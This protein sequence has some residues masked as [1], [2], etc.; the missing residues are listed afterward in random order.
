[1]SLTLLK[2]S[3]MKSIGNNKERLLMLKIKEHVDHA[4]L[5]E[6]LEH[7]K[8]LTLSKKDKPKFYLNK[9]WLIALVDMET[10]DAMEDGWIVLSNI[11]KIK[12]LPLKMTTLM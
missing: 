4:G 2:E 6:Q 10:K 3:R 5:S 9:I 8:A 1:M 7:S 12:E 11:S